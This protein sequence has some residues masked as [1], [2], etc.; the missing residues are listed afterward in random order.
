LSEEERSSLSTLVKSAKR[1]AAR[2]RTHAQV[3]LKIDEGEEGTGWTDEQAANAF[4]VHENTVRFIRRRL[5]EQGL[6]ATLNRKKQANPSRRRLL[7][8]AGEKEL[9]AVAQGEA[10]EGRARWTLR[11]LAGQLVQ[12]EIAPSISYETVRKALKK[13]TCSP[14]AK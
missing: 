5:V 4:D 11:L 2:T 10:P 7:D 6:E 14:T 3:L 12:L 8:E 1:I 13:T 9:L